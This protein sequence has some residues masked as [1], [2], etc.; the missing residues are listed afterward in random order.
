MLSGIAVLAD[1]G[2]YLLHDDELIRYER[3]VPCKLSRTVV[4]LDVQNCI[5]EAEQVSQHRIILVIYL[6]QLR[7][8]LILLAENTLLDNLIRR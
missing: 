5:R 4:S 1:L 7:C 3:E 6:F 8:N 2:K